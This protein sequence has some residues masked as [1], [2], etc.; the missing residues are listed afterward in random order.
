MII[1]TYLLMQKLVFK[2]VSKLNWIKKF[3]ASIFKTYSK[4]KLLTADIILC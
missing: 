4:Q 2:I 1:W 3:I